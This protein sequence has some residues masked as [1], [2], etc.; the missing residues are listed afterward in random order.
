[1]SRSGLKLMNTLFSAFHYGPAAVIIIVIFVVKSTVMMPFAFLK[2]LGKLTTNMFE[3]ESAD[4]MQNRFQSVLFFLTFGLIMMVIS[5][6]VDPI[7]F[8]YNL[9]IV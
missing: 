7:V 5:L 3:S 2:H 4:Q 8:T 6:I 9:F 1:M